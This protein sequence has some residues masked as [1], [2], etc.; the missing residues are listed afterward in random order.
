MGRC[1]RKGRVFGGKNLKT[2]G[3]GGVFTKK[4][5]PNLIY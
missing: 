3:K 4:V 5:A 2:R 1:C